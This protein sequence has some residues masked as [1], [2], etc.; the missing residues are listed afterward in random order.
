MLLNSFLNENLFC[1]AW[2]VLGIQGNTQK[3]IGFFD[4]WANRV[5]GAGP[6]FWWMGNKKDVMYG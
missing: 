1:L 3:G 5:S 2:E 6:P 4:V